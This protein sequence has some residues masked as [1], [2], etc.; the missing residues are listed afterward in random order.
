MDV[1]QK[2][3][4]ED[5]DFL[6]SLR[7]TVDGFYICSAAWLEMS[8]M[9]SPVELFLVNA[10]ATL[11]QNFGRQLEATAVQN[12]YELCA[13]IVPGLQSGA[14]VRAI[15]NLFGAITLRFWGD[16]EK[17]PVFQGLLCILEDASNSLVA[18]NVLNL[19][20]ATI[21]TFR[22]FRQECSTAYGS[23]S[24]HCVYDCFE[25][26][27]KYVLKYKELDDTVVCASLAV[28][29]S[30][31]C[32][33]SENEDGFVVQPGSMTGALVIDDVE[34]ICMI[35]REKELNVA[36]ECLYFYA[37]TAHQSFT[38]A[39]T[40]MAITQLIGSALSDMVR[41]RKGL[42]EVPNIFMFAKT[43]EKWIRKVNICLLKDLSFASDLF[44]GVSTWTLD[45]LKHGELFRMNQMVYHYALGFWKVVVSLMQNFV[46]PYKMEVLGYVE[47]IFKQFLCMLSTVC[48][49][50]EEEQYIIFGDGTWFE[51]FGYLI[52]ANRQQLVAFL[53]DF[54]HDRDSDLDLN[55]FI[56]IIGLLLVCDGSS[57]VECEE[58]ESMYD[59][60][61]PQFLTLLQT[62]N[63]GILF[64]KSIADVLSTY[65]RHGKLKAHTDIFL[66]R[67]LKAL[68]A[69]STDDDV[70]LGIIKNIECLEMN[71]EMVIQLISFY[72]TRTYRAYGKRTRCGFIG[73]LF[74]LSLRFGLFESFICYFSAVDEP[75]ELAIDLTGL[76]AGAGTVQAYRAVSTWFLNE[77]AHFFCSEMPMQL[78]KQALKMWH[79][80]TWE[81]AKNK[82]IVFP[83]FSS[84]G[85]QLFNASAEFMV[86]IL[87]K[88][89]EVED[90]QKYAMVKRI[91]R[92]MAN[93]LDNR[94][95]CYGAYLL[96]NDDTLN[97]LISQYGHFVGLLPLDRV[98]HYKPA[99][100]GLW[101]SLMAL[102][103]RHL[104][105]CNGATIDVLMNAV[106][107]G[108]TCEDNDVAELSRKIVRVICDCVIENRAADFVRQYT[109]HLQHC[110]I[111]VWQSIMKGKMTDLS[112]SGPVLR[113]LLIIDKST[114]ALAKTQ[115]KDMFPGNDALID[116]AFST[117]ENKLDEILAVDRLIEF[118]VPLQKIY[119]CVQSLVK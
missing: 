72:S 65:K 42:S 79:F 115:T 111:S 57:V 108:I 90:G 88:F 119:D 81:E 76:F 13:S 59:V 49:Q 94:Y 45:L 103:K 16:R 54:F 66:G 35:Y 84:L 71:K 99:A 34:A 98:I 117:M 29:K 18:A 7:T 101:N 68:S 107:F 78:T 74:R 80:L 20:E 95:V 64:E 46:L 27:E 77:Y 1:I 62:E 39:G 53:F 11:A 21:D 112:T 104:R 3:E 10:M 91:S 28:M 25:H 30:C 22:K 102:S 63:R 93:L 17:Q 92:V 109:A 38:D 110:A 44:A 32:Y 75:M 2:I 87:K 105:T 51:P 15:G 106:A 19:F 61:I 100:A 67:A 36:L 26:A 41:S 43:L 116:E 52:G 12:V 56:R 33:G 40:A 37:C 50:S 83:E 6:N 55:L 8:H 14:L 85:Q 86:P 47:D 48:Q 89:P 118:T 73:L 23:F 114:V 97:G 58:I 4:R 96:Y 113:L 69:L 70:S 82:R 31:L 5:V 24:G 60:L 9:G